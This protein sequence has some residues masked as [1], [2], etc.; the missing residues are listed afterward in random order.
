VRQGEER[1]G[2]GRGGGARPLCLL[3]L[4]ILATGACLFVFLDSV[5][6]GMVY[7]TINVKEVFTLFIF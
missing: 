1:G 5:V 6:V 3:V 4:T 2:K 7:L